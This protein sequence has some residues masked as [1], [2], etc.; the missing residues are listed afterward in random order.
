VLV[1]DGKKNREPNL[2]SRRDQNL[3]R[4][5]DNGHWITNIE[6]LMIIRSMFNDQRKHRGEVQIQSIGSEHRGSTVNGSRNKCT[7]VKPLDEHRRVELSMS[8]VSK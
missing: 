1:I 3:R 8:Q 7:K 4:K 5:S 6:Y 2:V